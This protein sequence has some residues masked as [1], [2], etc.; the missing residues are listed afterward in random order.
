MTG[1]LKYNAMTLGEL[2]SEIDRLSAQERRQL[3][4][5]LVTKDRLSDPEFLDELTRKID[6]KNPENWISLEE[7]EKRLLS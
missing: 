3:A 7:A 6:D 1:F 2:K 4:A 5:Y